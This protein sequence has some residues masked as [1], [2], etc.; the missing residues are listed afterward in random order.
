[1]PLEFYSTADF[2][3]LLLGEITEFL[4]GQDTGHPFQ[5][6][7]WNFPVGKVA[8]LRE[9][10][11]IRWSGAFGMHAPCG[12][13]FPWIRAVIA[14]RGPVC[15]DG[16]VWEAGTEEFAMQMNSDKCTYVDVSPDWLRGR[17]RNIENGF[18][19]STWERLGDERTSLRLDVTKTEDQIFAGFRKNSRYEV[20]RA[21]RVGVSVSLASCD[22]EIDEFLTLHRRLAIRKG[23]PDA[24]Q[25][26]LQTAIRWLIKEKSRGTLLLARRENT[27]C[28]GAVVARS[29]RRCWYIW[30][31]ANKHDH[32]NVGHILQ[33]KA[34]LWAK[35]HACDEYDF[36]GYA[37]CA[38]SGPAWFKAGFGGTV[39][40][41]V[42]AHRKVF[43][44]TSYRLFRFASRM[45]E[46]ATRP[47]VVS[48]VTATLKPSC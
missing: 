27:I 16:K 18:C 4:D 21:E 42:P 35:S 7:Q 1:M 43:R 34:L 25:E 12:P 28:G 26:H 24:V 15:D 48:T 13:A 45:R 5:F 11:S 40:S 9:S 23:F 41:F 44:P 19:D 31:A 20:R 30:G 47:S 32:F 37:P 10:G 17:V 2:S 8:L 14:N 29:G 33:W 3:P 46:L 22:S 38:T 36:G 39:V 6:P